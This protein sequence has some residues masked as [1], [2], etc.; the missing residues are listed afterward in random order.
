MLLPSLFYLGV[1][2]LIMC[3]NYIYRP[4]SYHEYRALSAAVQPLSRPQIPSSAISPLGSLPAQR[5]LGWLPKLVKKKT[6]RILEQLCAVHNFVS[7]HTCCDQVLQ[8][9]CILSPVSRIELMSLFYLFFPNAPGS[10][11]LITLWIAWWLRE[12]CRWTCLSSSSPRWRACHRSAWWTSFLQERRHLSHIHKRREEPSI[13]PRSA[14]SH[15]DLI[16]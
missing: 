10:D 13:C 15:F 1:F 11:T 8:L 9:L 4:P 2:C 14:V 12:V 16:I 6:C 5:T 7:T 3:L